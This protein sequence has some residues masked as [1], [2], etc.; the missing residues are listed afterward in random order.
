MELV[1]DD[2]KMNGAIYS[3]AVMSVQAADGSIQSFL[4]GNRHSAVPPD[5]PVCLVIQEQTG[6][7]CLQI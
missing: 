1:I 6:G 7:S 3:I 5:P 4:P 2:W